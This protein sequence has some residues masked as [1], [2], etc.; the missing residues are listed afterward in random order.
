[1]KVVFADDE[2]LMLSRMIQSLEGLD[3][4]FGPVEIVG[5]ACDGKE[6]IN[7]V[8]LNGP[9]DLVITDM[10]MPVKDGLSA[11]VYLREKHKQTKVILLTSDATSH[12]DFGESVEEMIENEKKFTMLE[13]IAARVR[14]G[15]PEP[16][17]I[18]SILEGCEKLALVP[19]DVA[20]FFGARGFVRKPFSA[21]KLNE[22]LGLLGTSGSFIDIDVHSDQ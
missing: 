20:A 3:P 10:R 5:E 2:P 9:V 1:M 14:K 11:L 4:Q 8:E 15:Q 21:A 19:K 17:K 12:T 6:L 18:N 7:I 13:K 16:G 22:L